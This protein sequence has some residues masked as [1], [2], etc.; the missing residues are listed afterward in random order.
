MKPFTEVYDQIK[1]LRGRNLTVSNVKRTQH[2]LLKEN[3]YNIINGY[4]D[5]FLEIKKDRNNQQEEKYYDGVDFEEIYSLYKM[6]RKIRSALLL[7]LMIFE[8]KFKSVVAYE[9][10]KKFEGNIAY[11]DYTNYNYKGAKNLNQVMK[12]IY[13]LT[14]VIKKYSEKDSYNSIKHYLRQYNGVPL[15]VLVNYLTFGDISYIHRSLDSD[16]KQKIARN[17]SKQFKEDYGVTTFYSFA[18][19]EDV[20]FNMV[21]YRNL[22]AHNERLYC[23]ETDNYIKFKNIPLAFN[24][25]NSTKIERKLH[26][27]NFT[28]LFGLKFVLP[29]NDYDAL[30]NQIIAIMEKYQDK[31]NT[32]S[33]NKIKKKLGYDIQDLKL[34][35]HGHQVKHNNR[36]I[37]Y[38]SLLPKVLYYNDANNNVIDDSN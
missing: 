34:L 8:N 35:I 10:T 25:I 6:D 15:W 18:E 27:N 31:I 12:N 20:V 3:Y 22:C 24:K 7:Y 28:M 29:K 38:K 11:L 4:K 14:N 23:F 37:R 1:I 21:L 30:I 13:I 9:F 2:L 17:F 19:F 36:Y 16:L 32:I 5:P 33:L 26:K